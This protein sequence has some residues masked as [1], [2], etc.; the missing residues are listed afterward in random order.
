MAT[1]NFQQHLSWFFQTCMFLLVLPSFC[2]PGENSHSRKCTTKCV[3]IVL[4]LIE[5]YSARDCS[6]H[7]NLDTC[8]RRFN[9][10]KA[11]LRCE[12]VKVL[13][14]TG[15]VGD[16]ISA[17]IKNL[18]YSIEDL[19]DSNSLI[20]STVTL[21]YWHYHYHCVSIAG[22]AIIKP[23][24]ESNYRNETHKRDRIEK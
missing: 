20:D 8:I 12:H 13:Y 18:F 7:Y 11:H 19:S 3:S 22:V 4:C 6:L 21:Y 1:K 5:Q 10:Q 16:L 15:S 2:A 9:C 17:T 24:K 14:S 23:E